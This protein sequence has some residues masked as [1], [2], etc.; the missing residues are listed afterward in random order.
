MHLSNSELILNP[1]GS[2][3]HLCLQK[4]QVA[5]LII[6]VGDQDRVGEVSKHFDRIDSKVQKREFTTHTGELNDKRITVISTGIGTDNIDI[7]FNE[8]DALFNIDFESRTINEDF[9]ELQ[10]I[11]IGTSGVL[12]LDID[13]DTFLISEYAIGMDAL[14]HYY[15]YNYSKEEQYLNDAFQI[16]IGRQFPSYVAKGS[17]GLM[18]KFDAD[19][20]KGIT[21]T[22]PGF[23]APQGRALRL[24]TKEEDFISSMQSFNLNNRRITN[25]EMETSGI[26]GLANLLGHQA[27]SCNA[28]LANRAN[29]IFSKN[30]K[31]TVEDLITKTLETICS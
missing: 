22:A 28:L 24:K 3:Y 13:V 23:Y 1:D 20:I 6:T 25:L 2:I 21:I 27:V 11:R 9:Q 10:F 18:Q 19:F 5:P 12:Q 7:V 8:L 30:P 4:D 14:I 16:H 17:T 29:G 31:K 26:Y 15:Q